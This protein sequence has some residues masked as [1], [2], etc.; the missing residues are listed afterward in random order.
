L[1]SDDDMR[2]VLPEA[3]VEC[4]SAEHVYSGIPIPK[5]IRV[6]MFSPEEW[7]SFTEEWA[8]SLKNLYARV[9][10]HSGSGDQGVDVVGFKS[11]VG[12]DGG[13]DNYQCK[14][15][16]HPLSPSDIWVEIGKVIYYSYKQEYPPPL[17]YYFIASR[18][19]S[20]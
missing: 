3:L 14:Q 15:Y 6:T 2:P 16:D 18:G 1:I 8:T 5:P 19:V 17:N 9:A 4:S 12:W 10:R 20:R 13:W 7:E 11:C